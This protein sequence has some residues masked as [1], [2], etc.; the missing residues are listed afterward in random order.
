M[1]GSQALRRGWAPV[2]V[3]LIG[4][5]CAWMASGEPA[6]GAPGSQRSAG[7]AA[8]RLNELFVL[9]AG[10]GTLRQL[11]RKGH[12]FAL[13]LSTRASVAVFTDRPQ[14]RAGVE[15]VARLVSGWKMLGFDRSPPNAALELAHGTHPHDVKVFE[16]R[17]P[18]YNARTGKLTFQAQ[19]LGDRTSTA[20]TGVLHNAHRD[21]PA[22]FH[23]ATLFIDSG[24]AASPTQSVKVVM[25]VAQN[26]PCGDSCSAT[27]TFDSDILYAE[28]ETNILTTHGDKT[29]S[30]QTIGPFPAGSAPVF[31]GCSANSDVVRCATAG[32]VLLLPCSAPITGS[33]SLDAGATATL[34]GTAIHDGRFSVPATCQ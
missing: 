17:S 34:N 24:S 7:A 31:L 26:A 22:R 25:T 3:G 8:Q 11:P 30:K 1:T 18:N 4:A 19:D 9:T 20:L 15:P 23:N 13:T 33:L 5:A 27:F 14:R 12:T 21:I 6:H 28:L 32:Q 10:T 29:T 2:L 16:L